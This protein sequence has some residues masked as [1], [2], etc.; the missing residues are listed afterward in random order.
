VPR[1][2][3]LDAVFLGTKSKTATDFIGYSE[4]YDDVLNKEIMQRPLK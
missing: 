3:H 4:F 2:T 1:N